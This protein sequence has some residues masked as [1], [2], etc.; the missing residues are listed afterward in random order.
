MRRMSERGD[1]RLGTLIFFGLLIA[2]GLAAWNVVPVYYAHYDFTDAVEE[3][4]RTPV[5][6]ARTPQVIKDMLM[7]EVRN[8]ELEQWVTAQSFQISNTDRNRTIRLNYEREVKVLPG[9][10]R[11]IKFNYVAEQPLL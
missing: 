4:C 5:Y 7:K 2:F 9:W 10:T 11:V 1:S 6:K 3:I 8:R